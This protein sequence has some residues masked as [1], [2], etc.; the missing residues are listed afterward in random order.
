MQTVHKLYTRVVKY[1][2]IGPEEEVGGEALEHI[3]AICHVYNGF[4]IFPEWHT[5]SVR[6]AQD[7]CDAVSRSAS[8]CWAGWCA[9]VIGHACTIIICMLGGLYL[10]CWNWIYPFADGCERERE[11]VMQPQKSDTHR[12]LE[13]NT[14]THARTSGHGRAYTLLLPLPLIWFVCGPVEK[15]AQSKCATKEII[16]QINILHTVFCATECLCISFPKSC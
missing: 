5:G 16:M 13:I 1:M 2:D 7:I 9:S 14:S 10:M 6:S 3:D 11:R 4:S 12:R 15:R 8:A